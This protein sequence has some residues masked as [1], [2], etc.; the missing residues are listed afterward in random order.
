[1]FKLR[2]I[3]YKV[4]FVTY[5]ASFVESECKIQNS[6]LFATGVVITKDFKFE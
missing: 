3:F 4:K 1:M 5:L 6:C 2:L